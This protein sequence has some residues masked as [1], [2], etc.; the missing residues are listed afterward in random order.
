M[1]ERER[2]VRGLILRLEDAVTG[3]GA[4]EQREVCELLVPFAALGMTFLLARSDA[5][6][7]LEP[8]DFA[9]MA[10]VQRMLNALPTSF[11]LIRQHLYV[12]GIAASRP[13][14]EGALLLELF[15]KD[16]GR[17]KDWFEKPETFIHLGALR[18]AVG[19]TSR[20]PFYSWSSE[21][22]EHVTAAGF[23]LLAGIDPDGKR[24][25]LSFG[26]RFDP[27]LQ[28]EAFGVLLM[29]AAE[30]SR[31]LVDTFLHDLE[32]LSQRGQSAFVQLMK[33]GRL[34]EPRHNAVTFVSRIGGDGP[35]AR[36]LLEEIERGAK[37]WVEEAVSLERAGI[38]VPA[39]DAEF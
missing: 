24:V 22:G 15:L 1:H 23:R 19:E 32:R 7:E 27:R 37:A 16:P 29:S 18:K 25:Q 9:R 26:G 20:D 2:I 21:H 10:V 28:T 30:A 11:G 38:A 8:V 35:E 33:A 5:P 13:L 14:L 6:P 4:D 3:D 39:L 34:D 31:A 12:E 17:G 36:K